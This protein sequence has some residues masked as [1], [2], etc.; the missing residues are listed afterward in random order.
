MCSM[1]YRSLVD[2]YFAVLLI[3]RPGYFGKRACLYGGFR[4][5]RADRCAPAPG[6][7]FLA[8]SCRPD[9]NLPSLSP[10]VL[11]RKDGDITVRYRVGRV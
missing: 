6:S 7:R 8:V 5:V 2:F 9:V 11:F 1:P 10:S 3:I 4:A